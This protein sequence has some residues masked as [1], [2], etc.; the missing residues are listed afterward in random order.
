MSKKR[1]HNKESSMSKK[2]LDAALVKKWGML[3]PLPIL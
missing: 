3:Y 1:S 2:R